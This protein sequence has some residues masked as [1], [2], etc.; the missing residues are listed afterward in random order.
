MAQFINNT[1]DKEVRNKTLTP[2]TIREEMHSDITFISRCA[3]VRINGIPLSYGE[4][5]KFLSPVFGAIDKTKYEIKF[6]NDL[7]L[8]NNVYIIK[9]IHTTFIG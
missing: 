7:D 4:E 9:S 1:I 8:D 2:S 3:Q 5:L 6:P